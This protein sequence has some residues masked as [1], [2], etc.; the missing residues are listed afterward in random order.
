MISLATVSFKRLS[1]RTSGM[2]CRFM[3]QFK[4][5]VVILV[6]YVSELLSN[7]AL[8]DLCI[9]VWC[10]PLFNLI[11]FESLVNKAAGMR[12]GRVSEGQ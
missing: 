12:V 3:S 4:R 10:E 2:V 8:K 11:V 5:G 1:E 7:C 6:W 9:C